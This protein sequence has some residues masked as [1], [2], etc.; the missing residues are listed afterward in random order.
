MFFICIVL[1]KVCKLATPNNNKMKFY[2]NET[3]K[4]EAEE[5]LYVITQIVNRLNNSEDLDEAYKIINIYIDYKVYYEVGRCGL[6]M[7][8]AKNNE[9]FIYI[10]E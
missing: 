8:V 4:I 3:Q 9:R 7:W 1:Q 6:Y 5:K 10:T 2:I